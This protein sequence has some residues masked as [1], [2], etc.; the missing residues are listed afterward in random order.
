[1][2]IYVYREYPIFL[3]YIFTYILIYIYFISYF[4]LLLPIFM[5]GFGTFCLNMTSLP[6]QAVDWNLASS[7]SYIFHHIASFSGKFIL[8]FVLGFP[9]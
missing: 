6:V 9:E 4:Y 7:E 8:S 5:R 1:M 2:C 3:F